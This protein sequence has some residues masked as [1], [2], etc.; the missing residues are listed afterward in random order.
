MVAAYNGTASVKLPAWC[1]ACRKCL[2]VSSH[3]CC[4]DS[5]VGGRMHH[6][7]TL[8]L[9][10]V[11]HSSTHGL[12]GPGMPGGPASLPHHPTPPLSD[13]LSPSIHRFLSSSSQDVQ[14]PGARA[15]PHPLQSL[16]YLPLTFPLL[17]RELATRPP[18]SLNRR[19]SS[20]PFS[21]QVPRPAPHTV[22]PC[23]MGIPQGCRVLVAC[24]PGGFVG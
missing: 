4:Q 22:L 16:P 15:R 9:L 12:A 14:L 7:V 10:A 6:P 8:T 11:A 21:P 5:T 1:Q 2:A 24:V 23:N 17:C 19:M 3:C 20:Q 13:S 18:L